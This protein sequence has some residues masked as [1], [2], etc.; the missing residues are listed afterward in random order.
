MISTV[1]ILTKIENNWY[2]LR[3]YEKNENRYE[4]VW[5]YSGSKDAVIYE[6][7]NIN[8]SPKNF[9]EALQNGERAIAFRD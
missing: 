3:C 2:V 4:I 6:L 9:L 7:K 5:S 8:I 1:Y